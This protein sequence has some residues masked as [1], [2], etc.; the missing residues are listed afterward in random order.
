M[1]PLHAGVARL[2]PAASLQPGPAA[3]EQKI[4]SIADLTPRVAC[5]ARLT[6]RMDDCCHRIELAPVCVS[7]AM[8]ALG[9][10]GAWI[11]VLL[12]SISQSW[13][14]W[15]AKQ[16]LPDVAIFV[17]SSHHIVG[18]RLGKEQGALRKSL[19]GHSKKRFSPEQIY[20]DAFSWWQTGMLP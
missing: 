13:M 4:D 6:H 20:P 7:A 5:D 16:Q 2:W 14:T 18:L 17:V 8:D 15:V 9:A 3:R 11:D 19:L 12:E 10:V 1:P